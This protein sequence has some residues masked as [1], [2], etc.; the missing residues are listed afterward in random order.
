MP[1]WHVERV[2]ENSAL[3]IRNIS[4][5][6]PL[7]GLFW[8]V[9]CGCPQTLVNRALS[10][11]DAPLPFTASIPLSSPQAM[12]RNSLKT[13]NIPA[14]QQQPGLSKGQQTFNTL[15]EKIEK[16]RARLMEWEAAIPAFHQRYIS[17]MAPLIQ[18]LDSLKASLVV[19]LDEA[20]T[21]R[22]LTK[23]ERATMASL[24]ANWAGALLAHKED[25]ALKAIYNRHSPSDFDSQPATVKSTKQSQTNSPADDFAA[26][27]DMSSLEAML[28]Q[29]EAEREAAQRQREAQRSERKKSLKQQAEQA[30][31][32][33]ENAE[34]SLSI[35][36]IY[37][38][39]ASALHPD[40]E[41]DPAERERKTALMQRVNRAYENNSLLQLLELQLELEQIDQHALRNLSDDRLKHYN[42]I[43]KEQVAELDQEVDHVETGFKQSYGISYLTDV[44]PSTILRNLNNDIRMQQ[45]YIDALQHDL[46]MIDDEAHLKAW[47]KFIQRSM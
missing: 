45:E 30:R 16:R 34:V 2:L 31:A 47:L 7:R 38:K 43:L 26:D 19:R 12:T 14:D 29:Q 25:A 17:K 3:L 27:M 1:L 22:S 44:S 11:N 4:V 37:R 23:G 10:Y 46:R 36:Q 21:L 42:K 35:R 6:K 13:I 24:I 20:Y 8:P 39:L 33:E 9:R 5:Y 40:R 32:K 41:P 28:A 18:T 15:I